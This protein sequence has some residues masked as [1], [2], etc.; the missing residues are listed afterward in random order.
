LPLKIHAVSPMEIV[1]GADK[2]R[3]P[4]RGYLA[5]LKAEGLAACRGRQPRS[6]M[7]TSDRFCADRK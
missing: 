5:M 7:T 6:W 1:Y 2:I 3:M 4:L